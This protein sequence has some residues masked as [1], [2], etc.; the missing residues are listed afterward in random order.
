MSGYLFTFLIKELQNNRLPAL[1]VSIN[2]FNKE[3]FIKLSEMLVCN[4]SVE[5]VFFKNCYCPNTDT[6][7]IEKI[8]K[9]FH[10]LKLNKSVKRLFIMSCDLARILEP[11]C[12]VLKHNSTIELLSFM[13]TMFL[14]E[15]TK[16]FFINLFLDAL[17]ENKTIK[18]ISLFEEIM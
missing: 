18:E 10:H 1:E 13:Q 2:D 3:Q 9:F 15:I 11:L 5:E 17:K 7:N 16:D 8:E 6:E 4:T 12:S 14:N